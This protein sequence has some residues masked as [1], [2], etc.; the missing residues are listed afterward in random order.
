VKRRDF[1]AGSAGLLLYAGSRRAM[2]AKQWRIGEVFGGNPGQIFASALGQA[3]LDLGN[4]DGK[5]IRLQTRFAAPSPDGQKEVIL[6]LLPDIDLLVVHGTLGGAVAKSVVSNIP[7]VFISVGA[8]VD[9]G[10]VQSLAHPGGNMTGTTFEAA[11][12]TY[13]KRLQLLKEILPD[14]SRVAVLGARGDPNVPFAIKSLETSAPP[15]GVSL[16]LME[17]T[18][19]DDLP[20]A[21]D[22]MRQSQTQ[23]LVVVA[24]V[25][26]F[27]NRKAI[28]EL[29]LTNGLPSCHGFKETV[30]AGELISLGPDLQAVSRQGAGLVDRIIKG[31]RPADLPV[32]QP[33]RYV[34]T[35][36]LKTA[37]TLGITIPPTLLARADEV[38]E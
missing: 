8:P 15:L 9:I 21:F 10:L 20:G 14:L 24:G 27:A 29:A 19:A 22:K 30:A 31:A 12:E 33:T 36:N 28:A 6:A 3:L 11:S 25:L 38:I 17:T 23:A 32:E 1:I 34:M 16:T 13:G 35:I 18:S 4:V 2:A 5:D 26:T 37:K 7:V